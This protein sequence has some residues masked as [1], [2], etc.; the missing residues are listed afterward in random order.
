ME[1]K[2]TVFT[3]PATGIYPEPDEFNPHSLRYSLTLM[4]HLC[5]TPPSGLYPSG[6]LIK[7]LYSLLIIPIHAIYITHPTFHNLNTL[8][9]FSL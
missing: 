3:R 5:L 6:F 2:V 8:I 4:L 9:K 7:I 1:P